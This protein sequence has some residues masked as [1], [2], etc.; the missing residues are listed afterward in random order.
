MISHEHKCIFIHQRKCAGVSIMKAFGVEPN[1][2]A[3]HFL[4]DGV[5]SPEYSWHGSVVP[6]YYKFSI[7]RNPWDRFVSGWLYCEKTRHLPI[8]TVLLHM[9]YYVG[10]DYSHIT[11]PQWCILYDASGVLI[12]N[13]VMRFENLQTDFDHVCDAIGKPRVILGRT[14]ATRERLPYQ[15]YFRDTETKDLFHQH[16][17]RDIETF[18]YSFDGG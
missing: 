5:L 8:K 10:H 12:T 15:E 14:N 9:L 2:Q 1:D 7:V 11:R 3:T 4:N 18:G 16:F 17:K 6:N 13:Y